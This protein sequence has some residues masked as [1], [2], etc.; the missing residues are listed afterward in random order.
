MNVHP[1]ILAVAI[2]AIT[3]LLVGVVVG[4]AYLLSLVVGG[5]SG[6]FARHLPKT[7]LIG[8]YDA[9]TVKRIAANAAPPVASI[10]PPLE[11]PVSFPRDRAL[12]S[13]FVALGILSIFVPMVY[14]PP[15]RH[16]ALPDILGL[17]R[18]EPIVATPAPA[19]IVSGEPGVLPKTAAGLPAGQS[20]QGKLLFAQNGCSSCHSIAPNQKLVGPSLYGIWT[21][22]S[23]RKAGVAA[24][25]YVYESIINPNAFIVDGFTQGLMPPSFSQALTAQQM[26][27]MMAYME[28]DLNQK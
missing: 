19:P 21:T 22:A 10:R 2:A 14:A 13:W 25:E 9:A 18:P 11:G 4:I 28:K 12:F 17:Y 8:V 26:A 20:A 1:L 23:T 16:V 5:L 7:D 24:K 3:L 6:F 15:G 27:D